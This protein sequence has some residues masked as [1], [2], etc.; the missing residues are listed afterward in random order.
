VTSGG[1]TS[2]KSAARAGIVLKEVAANRGR[3]LIISSLKAVHLVFMDS[4]QHELAR[5]QTPWAAHK[6]VKTLPL[7]TNV[8]SF[9]SKP[10][11]KDRSLLLRALTPNSAIYKLVTLTH[12][13]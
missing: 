11:D 8:K 13:Y 1:R 3:V 6:R 2:L 7:Y 9:R 4:I 12:A 10:E 5:V